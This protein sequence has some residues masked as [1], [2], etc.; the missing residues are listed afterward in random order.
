[1]E[2]VI[3]TLSNSIHKMGKLDKIDE[4]KARQRSSETMINDI[5]S[6]LRCE[7]E[8]IKTPPTN[9]PTAQTPSYAAIAQTSQKKKKTNNTHTIKFQ[10]TQMLITK[11]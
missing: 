5:V 11:I 3:Q 9:I 4:L 10:K 2:H 1:M 7:I 8:N 6:E